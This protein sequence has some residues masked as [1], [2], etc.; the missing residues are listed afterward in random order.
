MSGKIHRKK[1]TG[2]ERRKEQQMQR[3]KCKGL[4]AVCEGISTVR[5]SP[6]LTFLPLESL[7][8]SHK[9]TNTIRMLMLFL[10]AS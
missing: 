5:N 8:F 1:G 7:M 2:V 9:R 3:S 6:N 10:R 4:L